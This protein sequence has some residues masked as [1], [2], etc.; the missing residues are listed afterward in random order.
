MI[1]IQDEIKKHRLRRGINGALPP[2]AVDFETQGNFTICA[3]R[4]AQRAGLGVAKRNPQT[5]LPDS[6]IGRKVALW[7]ALD[8]FYARAGA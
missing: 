6:D 4:R 1:N 5:D 7:R 3:V 8:R 2:K